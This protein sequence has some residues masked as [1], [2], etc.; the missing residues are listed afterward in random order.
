[1]ETQQAALAQR[2]ILDVYDFEVYTDNNW[3]SRIKPQVIWSWDPTNLDD[4]ST[5]IFSKKTLLDIDTAKIKNQIEEVISNK[6]S[7]ELFYDG[8]NARL[9]KF[10]IWENWQLH[11]GLSCFDY[12]TN[13]SVAGNYQ[14]I[15]DI[16]NNEK[17]YKNK[18]SGGLGINILPITSDG[19]YVYGKK[20][21]VNDYIWWIV[22]YPWSFEFTKYSDGSEINYKDYP[23]WYTIKKEFLEE[24]G[25]PT[26]FISDIKMHT[27]LLWGLWRFVFLSTLK[28]S[29]NSQEVKKYFDW[30][31][32][33]EHQDLIF[34]DDFEKYS[35]AVSQ[36]SEVKKK[37]VDVL[38]KN[39]DLLTQ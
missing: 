23:L 21:V 7:G 11:I 30:L 6:K 14:I 4:I 27:L 35:E 13:S 37:W 32:S 9:E 1:M 5:D 18:I 10:E 19:K 17:N 33:Q 16:L 31:S 28:L 22:E 12:S 29:I 25:V 20:K 39:I 2:K 8:Q 36:Q 24:T 3:L 34:F 15:S 38:K 26:R